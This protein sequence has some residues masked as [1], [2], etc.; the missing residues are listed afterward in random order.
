L[1]HSWSDSLFFGICLFGITDGQTLAYSFR[2]EAK[3]RWQIGLRET[4]NNNLVKQ[5]DVSPGSFLSWTPDGQDLLYNVSDDPR[6]GGNVWL[7]PLAGGPPKLVF[8]AKENKAVGAAWS[9][10]GRKLYLARSRTVSNIVR[11]APNQLN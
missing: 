8:D 2:D 9:P 1:P 10:D 5:L 4:A 3:K 7:Q 11:L 6:S